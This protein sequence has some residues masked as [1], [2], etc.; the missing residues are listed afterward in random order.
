MIDNA[1]L[2]RDLESVIEGITA[3]RST[4]AWNDLNLVVTSLPI[5]ED[6]FT[7]DLELLRRAHRS[8]DRRLHSIKLAAAA[9]E[10]LNDPKFNGADGIS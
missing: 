8:L 7:G 3:L 5:R 1:K 9:Q 6:S 4:D 10:R 2:A